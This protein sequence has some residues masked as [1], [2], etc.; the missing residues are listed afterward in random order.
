MI[1]HQSEPISVAMTIYLKEVGTCNDFSVVQFTQEVTNVRTGI[2]CKCVGHVIWSC[3]SFESGV[4][5]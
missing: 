4:Y 3:A 5:M 1:L 2:L